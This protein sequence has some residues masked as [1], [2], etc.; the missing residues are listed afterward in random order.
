MTP[1]FVLTIVISI[2]FCG[3]TLDL[4]MVERTRLRM[5]NAADA[6]ALGAQV[7]H[8]QEDANWL[9]NALL[10]AAQNGYT[11]GGDGGTV[12]VTVTEQPTTGAYAGNYDAVQV[13]ITKT[14]N[15]VF[16]G[17]LNGGKTTMTV[18]AVS[19]L[20]PCVYLTGAHSPGVTY[21]LSLQTG[22]SIGYWGGSM[23]GC[24]LYVNRGV[25]VNGVSSLWANATN[26]VGSAG[27]S[28]IA[29]GDFHPPRYNATAQADPLAY[30]PACAILNS[31][32]IHSTSTGVSLPSF[33]SCSYTGRTWAT[34]TTLSPGTYCG[35][36][37]FTNETVTLSPGAVH[38]DR[39][40]GVDELD[41]QWDGSDALLHPEGRRHIRP[42]DRQ[43]VHPES[44]GAF[45]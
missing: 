34:G 1:L 18:S 43:R 27:G 8:D 35:S 41:R 28:S 10:D 36:F 24:T 23:L 15:T 30:S 45:D 3:I 29:G 4:G 32:C 21:P 31:N 11:N 22:S 26:I 40:R 5:Q 39:G 44:L 37:N 6:A 7:S 2:L 13:T 17:S 14:M 12:S 16:M 33:S 9:N 25:Y 19:L 38:R 20:T 42:S